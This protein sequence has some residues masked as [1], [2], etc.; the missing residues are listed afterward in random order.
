[1]VVFVESGEKRIVAGISATPARLAEALGAAKEGINKL[2]YTRLVVHVVYG[3]LDLIE[4]PN[5]M[6]GQW[7]VRI[8]KLKMIIVCDIILICRIAH[9]THCVR[10]RADGSQ[11][12]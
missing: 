8:T 4:V 12:L 11:R 10:R 3:I 5:I 6:L 7:L 1:V 2:H 9:R